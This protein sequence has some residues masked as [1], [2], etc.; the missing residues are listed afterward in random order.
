MS[1]KHRHSTRSCFNSIILIDGYINFIADLN[2][3]RQIFLEST[4]R[5]FL[6]FRL[7]ICCCD[8]LLIQVSKRAML[9]FT[10]L[11]CRTHFMR[12]WKNYSKSMKQLP[13]FEVAVEFASL[14][15]AN[16]PGSNA[17]SAILI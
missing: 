14:P 7:L 9:R 15:P 2:L 5:G 4:K 3:N 17:G 6:I 13:T 8:R 10:W 1:L 16:D 12:L 11:L